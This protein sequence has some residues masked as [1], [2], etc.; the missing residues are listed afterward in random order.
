M[1]FGKA[2]CLINR[3]RDLTRC[4]RDTLASR[5]PCSSPNSK[6]FRAQPQKLSL[7]GF[8]R[9][10]LAGDAGALGNDCKSPSVIVSGVVISKKRAEAKSRHGQADE[11]LGLL[12]EKFMH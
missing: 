4:E 10:G 12:P 5:R 11:P 9:V 7:N 1:Y 8:Q 2:L 3:S 6:T